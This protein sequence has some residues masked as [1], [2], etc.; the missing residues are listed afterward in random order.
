MR[1]VT[2]F[3]L[4]FL[5]FT[6]PWEYSLDLG[7]P[8]GNIARIAGLLALF[9]AVP[10]V[11]MVGRIRVPGLFQWLTLALFLWF[12]CT[13]FW[14]IDST[15]T[16]IKLRAYFQE[17][18]IV[19]LVWEFADTPADLRNL[20][21]VTVAG[22]WF[23]AILTLAA[24]R[25]PEAIA[26]GQIRFAA[27]GQDPNEVARFLDLGFPLAALL[28]DCERRWVVRFVALGFL[29]LGLSAVLLTAS[30]GGFLAALVALTGST[31]LL[32]R[33]HPKRILGGAIAF[34]LLVGALWLIIPTATIDR[35]ATIPEQLRSGDLNQ[36]LNIWSAGWRAFCHA[37]FFGSGAG[38]FVIAAHLS[39]IDTA[40]NTALSIAVAGG[41]IAVFLATLLVGLALLSAL[42][43]HG[44]LR[45][46]LLTSLLVW[47]VTSLTATV[48][49]NRT[50]WLFLATIVL[51][52]RFAEE[53]SHELKK[54]FSAV[55]M[56]SAS[57][58]ASP[59]TA[60]TGS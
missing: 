58:S 60:Q 5:A 40:H 36:R 18:M 11:L 56:K 31:T 12:C 2:W 27:Y 29:P 25:S 49:E 42:K 34:P 59:L 3:L 37:P 16:L 26:A 52:G 41:L 43:T 44:P 47:G 7:Q 50:T 32:L 38:S 9:V 20:L 10:V 14:T 33:G 17:F 55:R 21:R 57:L 23:L 28:F 53:D 15:A 51:A 4:L 35:L 19:W 8:L 45:V 6:I 54:V 48:E 46:S 22:S 1:R 13:C 30:R 24:F 39:H